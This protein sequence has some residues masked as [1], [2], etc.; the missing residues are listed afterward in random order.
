MDYTERYGSAFR[1]PPDTLHR[2]ILASSGVHWLNLES[3]ESRALLRTSSGKK[4][5]TGTELYKRYIDS[6]TIEHAVMALM[7]SLVR[8]GKNLFP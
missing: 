4:A 8:T 1:G 2:P 7:T 6:K 5:G 3:L